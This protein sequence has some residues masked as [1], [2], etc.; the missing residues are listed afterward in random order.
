MM[1]LL[2]IYDIEH[3][4]TRS[5]VACACEDYG[6]DRIQYS[7]FYGLLSRT[8]QEELMLRCRR[9]LHKRNGNVQLIPVGRAEWDRRILIENKSE[10]KGEPVS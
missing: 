4:G 9:L 1:H 6:L 2:L 10:K 3:D 8:H 5:K 7:A